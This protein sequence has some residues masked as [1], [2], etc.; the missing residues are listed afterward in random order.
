MFIVMAVLVALSPCQPG[1]G[2]MG[3]SI[4]SRSTVAAFKRSHPC[5]TT[6]RSTGPCVGWI[7]DHRVAL[8]CCGPD[9]PSNMQWQTVK[10]AKA[11]DRIEQQCSL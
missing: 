1:R 7:V 11:K 10:D 3:H 8:V 9:A 6:H 5:P 2:G 4:R